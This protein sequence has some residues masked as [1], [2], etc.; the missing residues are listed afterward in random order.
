MQHLLLT[1]LALACWILPA[2]AFALNPA[3]APEIVVS[4]GTFALVESYD[5][6]YHLGVEFRL[7][8]RTRWRLAPALGAAFGPDGIGYAYVDLTRDF[9]LGRR[10]TLTPSLGGGRFANGDGIGVLDHLEFRT[11]LA[12]SRIFRNR[13]QL[14]LAVYH[15]SNAGL[16]HPN[17]GTEGLTL[18]ARLPLSPSR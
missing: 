3:Q 10:W 14:G 13:L 1:V 7:A 2:P 15:V 17:N 5:Y 9:G 11:G 12:I 16:S 18:F 8:P 6:P 4:A